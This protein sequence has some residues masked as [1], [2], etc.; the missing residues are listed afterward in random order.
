[1]DVVVGT[2]FGML[3]LIGVFIGFGALIGEGVAND[4]S[5]HKACELYFPNLTV[6]E[7]NKCAKDFLKG[8]DFRETKE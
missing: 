4:N 2:I 1:M 6:A 5:S 3:L 7:S 8:K